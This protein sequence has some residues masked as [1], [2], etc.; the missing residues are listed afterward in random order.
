MAGR[1]AGKPHRPGA[2]D[3]NNRTGGDPRTR[4]AVIAGRQDVRKASQVPD[5][6]HRLGFVRKPE[7][8]E[9]RVRHHDV[10]RLPADPSAHVHV[11]VR[12]ARP[13]GIDVQAD[14]RRLFFAVPASP[15]G[16]VER[17][18]N[19]VADFNKFHVA[20]G[21]DNLAGNFMP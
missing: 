10:F 13:R 3:I 6:L 16:N 2:R 4:G 11:A 1:G 15:A 18:R 12:R 17:H 20:A 21:F 14:S 7:Q 19:Q 8:V 5:F 9:V